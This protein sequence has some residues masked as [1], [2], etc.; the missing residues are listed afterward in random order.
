M[1]PSACGGLYSNSEMPTS[2][3]AVV[4]CPSPTNSESQIGLKSN[5]NSNKK[6]VN[7]FLFVRFR[8]FSVLFIYSL[9]LKGS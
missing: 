7:V 9:I 5:E 2:P 8:I 1:A 4:L 3:V 6:Y